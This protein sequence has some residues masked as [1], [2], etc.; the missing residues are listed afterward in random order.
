MWRWVDDTSS[1]ITD[2]GQLYATGSLYR[3]TC[4]YVPINNRQRFLYV[5][6]LKP[7][8]DSFWCERT[9]DLEKKS[10]IHSAEFWKLNVT[11]DT[12]VYAHRNLV[13]CPDGHVVHDFLSCDSDSHCGIDRDADRCAFT[14]QA[15]RR[16]NTG[17][18]AMT[19]VEMFHCHHYG[20]N[21]PFTLV[22]DFRNDC[23]DKSDEEAC[24]HKG[25][26]SGLL[27][28]RMKIISVNLL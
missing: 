15:R 7:S 21:I 23:L 13:K 4:S 18:K 20:G 17:D 24:E 19:S 25:D 9:I 14:G 27:Y 2:F 10:P 11:S 26:S 1:Y 8:C 12:L 5:D 3:D 28:E 22:C 6:C 16:N